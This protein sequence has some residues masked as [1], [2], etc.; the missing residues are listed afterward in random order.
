MLASANFEVS[1]NGSE[2]LTTSD[3]TTFASLILDWAIIRA[4]GAGDQSTSIDAVITESVHFD[5]RSTATTTDN[6]DGLAARIENAARLAICFDALRCEVTAQRLPNARRLYLPRTPLRRILQASSLQDVPKAPSPPALRDI[7]LTPPCAVRPPSPAP[8]HDLFFGGWLVNTATHMWEGVNAGCDWIASHADGPTAACSAFRWAAGSPRTLCC[9]CGGG[10]RSPPPPSRPLQSSL[11]PALLPPAAPPPG[12]LE[13]IVRVSARRARHAQAIVAQGGQRP[14]YEFAAAINAT[15]VDVAVTQLDADVRIAHIAP[16]SHTAV[17]LAQAFFDELRNRSKLES[18]L[19]D[20][21]SLHAVPKV[22][23]VQVEIDG[24]V[25]HVGAN[26]VSTNALSEPAARAMDDLALAP[27]TISAIST[28]TSAIVAST[29]VASVVTSVVASVTSTAAA[30]LTAGAAAGAAGSAVGGVAPLIFGAQ[31]F[32][33]TS[34]LAVNGSELQRSVA[35]SVAWTT[36]DL[37][38]FSTSG[39]DA[40]RLSELRDSNNV[41]KAGDAGE[42]NDAGDADESSSPRVRMALD[43]LISVLVVVSIILLAAL[44]IHTCAVHRWRHRVNASFYESKRN[45][46]LFLAQAVEARRSGVSGVQTRRGETSRGERRRGETRRGETRRGANDSS[47]EK[48]H[49]RAAI[50]HATRQHAKSSRTG[51]STWRSQST[52][53]RQRLLSEIRFRSRHSRRRW[54]SLEFQCWW[55]KCSAQAS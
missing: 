28:T 34:N 26:L 32:V 4:R 1:T 20:L 47:A 27:E 49:V 50:H 51:S 38:F 52:R 31:R 48:P 19:E 10:T 39:S 23:L 46:K 53:R 5:T 40:R 29:I 2:A 37:G 42:I 17:P 33:S 3:T 41:S 7:S 21:L 6:I 15:I 18:D 24:R 8:C 9:V 54:C 30:T 36:G 44:L 13:V 25:S 43:R 55:C 12:G 35:D 45:P 11:P 16:S 22:K 14:E